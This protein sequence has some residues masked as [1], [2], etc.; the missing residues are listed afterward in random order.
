MKLSQL[1][2]RCKIVAIHG[3]EN[4]EVESITSDSRQV[5]KGSLFIAVEGINTDGHDYIAKAIEQDVLVVVY[6]K[7]MFEEY[8]SR[9]T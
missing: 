2:E 8:F 9:V 1:T 7:P 6:D 3:E 5:Q 4:V